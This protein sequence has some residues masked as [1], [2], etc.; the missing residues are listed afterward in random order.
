MKIDECYLNFKAVRSQGAGGQHVNKTSTA[1]MLSVDLKDCGLPPAVVERLLARRDRRID[2]DGVLTIKAQN[3]RSQERNR[4][5]ALQRLEE[6]LEEASRT[7]KKRRPT[8]PSAS[9]RR[10]R[11]D[12]K[13]HRSSIK[14]L[15]GKV[16]P[17]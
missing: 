3:S 15:R 11:V 1:I 14:Q 8:K 12:S 17:S 5:E 9:A 4:Q 2:Q 13:K 10:K 6:L 16:D 7:V